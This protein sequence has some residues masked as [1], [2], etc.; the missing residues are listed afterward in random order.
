MWKW[1]SHVKRWIKT[2]GSLSTWEIAQWKLISALWTSLLILL[3]AGAMHLQRFKAIALSIYLHLFNYLP[4]KNNALALQIANDCSNLVRIIKNSSI[5]A[6][7]RWAKTQTFHHHAMR[8]IKFTP[9]VNLA[10]QII[11]KCASQSQIQRT[12]VWLIKKQPTPTQLSQKVSGEREPKTLSDEWNA[13]AALLNS[14]LMTLLV[15]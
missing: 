8:T 7:G 9:N 13:S 3:C 5:T 11:T 1:D 6:D 10:T 12:C 2:G 15:F 4:D 14:I